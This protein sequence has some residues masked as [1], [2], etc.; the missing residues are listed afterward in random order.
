MGLGRVVLRYGLQQRNGKWW[1]T[2]ETPYYV[3][4]EGPFTEC[5]PYDNRAEADSDRKGMQRSRS[6][7]ED[8]EEVESYEQSKEAIH[9]KEEDCLF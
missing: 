5:G 3:D 2:G 4:G 1:I 6:G 8:Y 7:K 9:E